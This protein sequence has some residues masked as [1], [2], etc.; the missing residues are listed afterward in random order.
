MEKSKSIRDTLPG[1]QR[2]RI[3]VVEDSKVDYTLLLDELGRSGIDHDATRVDTPEDLRRELHEHKPDLVISD[4]MLPSLNGMEVLHIVQQLDPFIPVVIATGSINEETAV[5]CIKAGAV[6]Y[7]LKDQ[8]KRL[9]PAV[10]LALERREENIVNDK[11]QKALQKLSSAVENTEDSIVIT[12]RSGTIEFVNL[13]FERTTG[14]RKEEVLGKTPRILK[15]DHQSR[16]FYKTMWENLLSGKTLRV[17]FLNRRKNGTLYYQDETITPIVDSE[18]NITS[19][20]STGRDI[21]ERKRAEVVLR[22]SQERFSKVFSASP[23]GISVATLEEGRFKEANEAF[24]ALYGYTREE[25]IG[26]TANDL[27]IWV[28]Q[29]DRHRMVNLL[30]ECNRV[31]DFETQIRTKSG[32]IKQVLFSAEAIEVDGERSILGLMRD[33]T[34]RK[35]AENAL[36]ETEYWIRESQRV[37]RIGSYVTDFTSG[38]WKSSE[39]LDE[40]FGID[41]D[42]VRSVDGWSHLVH[43]DERQELNAYL[44]NIIARKQPFNREYRIV[45]R[46]DRVERWVFGRGELSYDEQGKLLRMIGTIQDITERRMAERAL[47]DNAESFGSLFN[48][49]SDGVVI[50]QEGKILEANSALAL[51]SGYSRSE[52]VGKN[53][54]ELV[55]LASRD[56]VIQRLQSKYEK[57]FEALGLREDGTTVPVELSTA[58]IFY[59]G[60]SVRLTS[61]RDISE[62]KRAEEALRVSEDRFRTIYET[63]PIGIANV[64]RNGRFYRA[65]RALEKIFGYS[66][67]ELQNMSFNDITCP[68]DKEVT[69]KELHEFIDGREDN[70][71]MEKR[72]IHKNGSLI[73]AHLT[74]S[75][76][77]DEQGTLLYTVAMVEDITARRNAEERQ[78]ILEVQLAQA[79]KME[80]I[81]TLAGGIAHDFNNILGIILGHLSILQRQDYDASLHANSFETITKA[82]QRGANLVRQILTFARKTNVSSE[83][84][85]VGTIAQELSKM[86]RETFPKTID[87]GIQAESDLPTI[88]VDPT[89]FHQALMNL[90]I[91]ARDAMM[92]PDRPKLGS[93]KLNIGMSRVS[94]LKLRSRFLDADASQYVCVAV[95]DTGSGFDEATKQKIFEPFFTTKETGK[96]TGLGLAVVYGVVKSHQGF[97]DVESQVG[98]GTTFTLYFPATTSHRIADEAKSVFDITS[99]KGKESI[100]VVEDEEGLLTLMQIALERNGYKVITA[101]DGVEAIEQ[102]EKHRKEIALVLTDMGL[103]KLDGSEMFAMLKMRDPNIKVIL[104]SGYLEPQYKKALLNAGAKDFVQKPY[105]PEEVL[106]KIRLTLDSK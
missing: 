75:T 30:K 41:K 40:I 60:R 14:Y 58:G 44:E 37:G 26:H 96:G 39:V 25:V 35:R 56:L 64:D 99:Y 49:T 86:L 79:Q 36:Q 72:Y 94:G 4:Y 19:F 100:L 46:S 88:N 54:V 47:L 13:A 83:Q 104:A 93:G 65:N 90:C 67:R 32:D 78:R 28:N 85:N 97:I 87:I 62:R 53:V 34:E 16:E 2:P 42:Y 51:L 81:G 98:K 63:S 66:E 105:I 92:D 91:N 9:G 8:I 95:S 11:R 1:G 101:K 80:A 22:E 89:Q 59:L 84:V 70:A 17:E 82:V 77:R 21:T 52:L 106:R 15:S 5:E 23:V 43:P 76:V 33:I 10:K 69:V 68:E 31:S 18:G 20:V 38:Y 6:D 48:S 103:P 27:N 45:R 7:V 71:E 55:A 102:F 3:L 57:P 73:W 24:L 61:V 50:H 74:I 12:D 29:E